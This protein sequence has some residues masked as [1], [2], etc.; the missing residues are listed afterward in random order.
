[1]INWHALKIL[2]SVDVFLFLF[3]SCQTKSQFSDRISFME[4]NRLKNIPTVNVARKK[5]ILQSGTRSDMLV[6]LMSFLCCQSSRCYI[7]A[8]SVKVRA[9]L[10]RKKIRQRKFE[11]VCQMPEKE[12]CD[13]LSEIL[14]PPCSA[15]GAILLYTLSFRGPSHLLA[16]SINKDR[17]KVTFRLLYLSFFG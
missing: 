14:T 12:K 10:G 3:F 5:M 2:S 15:L 4:N 17:K 8:W 7:E 6:V 1:M 9:Y 16:M 11:S 13:P